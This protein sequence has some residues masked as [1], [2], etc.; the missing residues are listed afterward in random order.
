MRPNGVFGIL[1]EV[2]NR[3]VYRRALEAVDLPR[4]G[5]LFEIGFGT[6]ACLAAF[7]EKRPDI[8]VAGVDPTPDMLRAALA[9]PAIR[10][11]GPRARLQLGTAQ[12]LDW[13]DATFDAALAIHSFQFWSPPEEG[14]HETLR[15]LKPRGRLYLFLRDHSRGAPDWLPNPISRGGDEPAD[16]MVAARRCGFAEAIEAPGKG[17]TRLVIAAKSGGGLRTPPR[18]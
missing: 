7:L 11:A 12:S 6:G 3:P 16:T 4:G 18:S 17:S 2:Y 14:L 13:P 5:R 9:K 10:R 8:E 1:M 15:V